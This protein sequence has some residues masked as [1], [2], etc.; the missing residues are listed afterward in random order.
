MA[1]TQAVKQ[2]PVLMLSGHLQIAG[3][4]DVRAAQQAGRVAQEAPVAVVDE[5]V[6]VAAC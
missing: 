3:L 1:S 4:V 2:S 6:S 5:G